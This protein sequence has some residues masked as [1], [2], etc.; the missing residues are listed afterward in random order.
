MKYLY[1]IIIILQSSM[2]LFSQTP[3]LLGTHGS[4]SPKILKNLDAQITRYGFKDNQI[5]NAIE[6][7][8]TDAF[9]KARILD[10]LNIKQV[11]F[12]LWPDAT[13]TNEHDE[14]VPTGADSIEVF[15]YLDMFIDKIGPYI[16]YIQISQEP[17]GL[18]KYD[19]TKYSRQEVLNWWKA[20]ALFI[21][22]KQM[23][24]PNKLGHLKIIT[25]GI[26][27]IHKAVNNPNTVFAQS[28]DSIISFGENYCD[29]IDLHLHIT[30]ISMGISIIEYIINRTDHPLTCTEWSQA[31]AA[32]PEG[33]NWINS[34]NTV[35]PVG[36][37]FEGMTNGEIID[38]AFHDSTIMIAS[39]WDFLI[40][41]SPYT[42]GFIPD[43][44]AVMDSNCFEFA[45]YGGVFQYGNPKFD[46]KQLFANA[47]VIKSMYP[48]NPFYQEF[49]N[50][51][52]LI[53]SG[54]Y[55]TKCS[56]LS[57][58]DDLRNDSKQILVYPN[59]FSSIT[60]I[61]FEN[62][63]KDEFVFKLYNILGEEVKSIKNIVDGKLIV[64]RDNL[65]SGVYFVQLQSANK[66]MFG[67]LVIE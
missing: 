17:L 59:P 6:S 40:A 25:G 43:F 27:G 55:K 21:R 53:N 30:A 22:N 61:K 50:L 38:T 62:P 18:T 7:G 60:T 44:F 24:N 34:L 58:K 10:S 23:L 31:R 35:F 13:T 42:S 28:V 65:I 16:D 19:Y 47:T 11:V 3:I 45:C 63:G 33:T 49:I 56:A 5:R 4:N 39:E 36:H 46:W 15:L 1:T 64:N 67:I 52:N 37:P 57:V 66:K 29:A 8:N 41:T 12:L 32:F 51:S 20:V 48:N 9:D 2:L 14:R 26:N 54:Q